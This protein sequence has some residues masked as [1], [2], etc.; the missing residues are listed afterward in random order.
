M[1]NYL[2]TVLVLEREHGH[3]HVKDIAQTLGIKMPSVT[4]ALGKL[5]KASLVNY[6]RYGAVTLTARGRAIGR[7]FMKD[8]RVL[9]RFFR[10]VLGVD[11]AVAEED[12]CRIEHVISRRTL[13]KLEKLSRRLAGA[14]RRS[15]R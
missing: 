1:E 7:R 9:A 15:K 13:D 3:A 5:K 12:A 14:K 10:G 2:E 11:P 8:H 4:Q 6:G